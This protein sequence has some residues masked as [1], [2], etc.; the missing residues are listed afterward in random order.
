MKKTPPH[1][2]YFL[3]SVHQ[4]IDLYDRKL[5][6]LRKH[7]DFPSSAD[8]D[9]AESRLITKRAALEKT[10]R[11]L[12]AQGVEFSDTELPRSFGDQVGAEGYIGK[13]ESGGVPG[14]PSLVSGL[15]SA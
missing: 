8:R 4:E 13:G 10:A 3:R 5:A 9:E 12:A 11:E 7:M 15:G 6:H 14:K 2:K 1:D